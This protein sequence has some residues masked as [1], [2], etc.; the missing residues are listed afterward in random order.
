MLNYAY[1]KW[2]VFMPLI[3]AL[4]WKMHGQYEII[5]FTW[6]TQPI[7]KS[8]H[9][10]HEDGQFTVT[11]VLPFLSLRKIILTLISLNKI[12]CGHLI[13]QF[14]KLSIGNSY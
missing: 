7:E 2:H 12:N 10:V 14:F 9:S 13:I 6:L 11:Y 3:L 1:H 5:T 8:T 4:I